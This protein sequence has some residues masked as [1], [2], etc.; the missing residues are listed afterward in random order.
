M[1]AVP[2]HRNRNFWSGSKVA[3]FVASIIDGKADKLSHVCLINNSYDIQLS[4]M[5]ER[6]TLHMKMHRGSMY[7][8]LDI[9]LLITI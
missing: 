1:H 9:R 2:C 3:D 7:L 5:I 4:S 6:I 8:P